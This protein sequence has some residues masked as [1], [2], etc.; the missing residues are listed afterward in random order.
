MTAGAFFNR[1]DMLMGHYIGEKKHEAV[2]RTCRRHGETD[3][4][5]WL[6]ALNYF[7]EVAPGGDRL[8]VPPLPPREEW[9][10]DD[11]LGKM[12]AEVAAAKSADGDSADDD[13]PAAAFAAAYARAEQPDGAG[14]DAQPEEH[15]VDEEWHAHLEEVIEAIER[16]SLLQPRAL[17]DLLCHNPQLPL[18]VVSHYLQRFL[19]ANEA[20]VTEHN[21][22]AKRFEEDSA[23]MQAEI[24]EME[25]CARV[26]QNAKCS[27]CHEPLENPT[28]RRSSPLRRHHRPR[29]RPPTPPPS[30]RPPTRRFTSRCAG[31]LPL[32]ALVPRLVP[33]RA[34]AVARLPHL[35][36]AAQ[37]RRRAPAA[38]AAA[39]PQPRRVLQAARVLGGR[40]RHHRRVRR[41]RHALHGQRGA[42]SP[43]QRQSQG[44]RLTCGR[45]CVFQ[46]PRFNMS[47][48]PPLGVFTHTL[49]RL[50]LFGSGARPA[51]ARAPYILFSFGVDKRL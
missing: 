33:R 2:L 17:M 5:M 16:D 24:K 20:K 51:G 25:S 11:I 13:D 45:T 32:H 26:F 35:R 48:D 34:R 10:P 6:R 9:D 29:H 37:A 22:E 38:A 47:V 46:Y 40:L 19:E 1:Y 15:V 27:A 31:T 39:R 3:P 43:R 4:D 23:R 12:A 36:A 50:R 49:L 42:A 28:V 18:S 8:Q 14:L 21:R 41:P 30:R 7:V 44:R